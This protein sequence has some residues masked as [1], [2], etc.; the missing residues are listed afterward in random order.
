LGNLTTDAAF[1]LKSGSDDYIHRNYIEDDEN[2]VSSSTKKGKATPVTGSGV[3]LGCDMSKLQYFL[4]NRL[5]DGS[6]IVSLKR[7][8]PFTPREIPGI[9]FS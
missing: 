5:T 1:H 8:P 7:R 9:H 3:P 4:D 2:F 6:K